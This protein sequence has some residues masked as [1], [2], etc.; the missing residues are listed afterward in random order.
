[1]GK[2]CLI[3]SLVFICQKNLKKK[4]KKLLT[5]KK[6]CGIM[7]SRN[8]KGVFKLGNKKSNFKSYGIFS[9]LTNDRVAT[10]NA[11]KI[12]YDFLNNI[13]IFYFAHI[14]IGQINL[15]THYVYAFKK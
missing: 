8:T 5:N 9:R 6:K 15:D 1:M 14:V 3:V 11:T 12:E 13:C 10:I 7:V 2:A 4:L